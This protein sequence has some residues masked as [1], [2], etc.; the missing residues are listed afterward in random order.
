VSLFTG[1][2]SK[3]HSGSQEAG[4]LIL[5][6]AKNPTEFN[7][8]FIGVA[9]DRNRTTGVGSVR[10][11]VGNG[12]NAYKTSSELPDEALPFR[13]TEGEYLIVVDHDVKNDV[14]E[15][16]Y[17]STVVTLQDSSVLRIVNSAS[18]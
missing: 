17:K 3:I 12:Q 4:L 10:Y 9:F 7:S 8:T 14:L 1:E 16:I 2:G 13:V 11:R 5:A 18:Q 6:D 15:R